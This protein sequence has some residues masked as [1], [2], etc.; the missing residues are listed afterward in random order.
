VNKNEVSE[1][2]KESRGILEVAA[3]TLGCT[4]EELR[5]F[6]KTDEELAA[7]YGEDVTVGT[8]LNELDAI[9]RLAPSTVQVYDELSQD[10]IAAGHNPNLIKR[11]NAISGFEKNAGA[12][13]VGSLNLMYKMVV[14]SGMSLYEHLD[15]IKGKIN[16]PDATDADRVRWQRAYNVTVDQLGKNYDRVLQG[17][18]V[19]VKIIPGQGGDDKE[20]RKKPA[21]APIVK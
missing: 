6:I 14:D 13:L 2:I 18:Q 21:F 10:L 19:L 4:V 11:L 15:F 12:F 20:K 3:E 9:V 7:V 8:T 16:D 17:T 5:E 1:A